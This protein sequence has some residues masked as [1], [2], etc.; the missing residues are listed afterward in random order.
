MKF[1]RGSCAAC[2][3]SRH[4]CSLDCPFAPYFPA[5][6]PQI[7]MNVHRLY[8]PANV[9][10]ILNLLND[11]KRKEEAMRSVKYESYI[12]RVSP[13]HGCYGAIFYLKQLLAEMTRQ[14]QDV[15][16]LLDTYRNI[17]QPTQNSLI[18]SS[19]ESLPVNNAINDR[20]VGGSS[21]SA[22]QTIDE[23][24][25]EAYF[26]GPIDHNANETA[27]RIMA[28]PNNLYDQEIT[29]V[30]LLRVLDDDYD[31]FR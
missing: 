16:L 10:R 25:L 23:N 31:E 24:D 22:T 3:I 26:V 11:N 28:P 1:E 29:N 18:N 17:N 13:V 14:L 20:S 19:F 30:D 5:S 21:N 6:E 27:S 8:G 4:R 12:R 15:R 2:R 9:L 7:F